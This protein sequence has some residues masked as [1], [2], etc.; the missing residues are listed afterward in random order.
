MFNKILKKSKKILPAIQVTDGF[1]MIIEAWQ[2]NDKTIQ[3]ETTKRVQIT[4]DTEVKLEQIRSQRAILEKYLSESFA[5][6]K[7]MIQGL[8]DRLD[9]GIEIGDITVIQSTLGGIVEIAKQSPLDG[10]K[11]ILSDFHNPDV[12][13]IEI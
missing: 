6:R 11:H 5:E 4:A 7:F 13:S 1:K 3:V 9:K 8:F 12:K 10:I 2:E